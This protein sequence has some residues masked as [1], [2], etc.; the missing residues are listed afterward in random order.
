MQDLKDEIRGIQVKNFESRWYVPG[1]ELD[2]LLSKSAVE[3]AVTHC[4]MEAHR[5]MEAVQVIVKGAKKIFAVLVLM[6]KELSIL[7]F[8]EHDHLQDQYLDSKLPFRRSELGE[9]LEDH[10]AETF[11]RTQW[12]VSAP[13]FQND[14]SHRLLDNDTI[15]PFTKNVKVGCGAFG[16]V[17]EVSLDAKHQ[18]IWRNDKVPQVSLEKFE[19]AV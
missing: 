15:L 9:I 12:V 6:G 8:I 17:F 11:H 16:T 14:M 1:R 19:T 4:G 2:K 10:L 5:Q 3:R 7:N 18:G 13:I